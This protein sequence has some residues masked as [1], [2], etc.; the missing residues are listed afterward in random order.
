MAIREKIIQIRLLFVIFDPKINIDDIETSPKII[1]MQTQEHNCLKFKGLSN[2]WKNNKLMRRIGILIIIFNNLLSAGQSSSPTGME[3]A[4]YIP[5]EYRNHIYLNGIINNIRGNFIFDTG[6]DYLY[7]DSAFYRKGNFSFDSVAYGILPGA[8]NTPQKTKVILNPV[9]VSFHDNRYDSRITPIISLKTILGDYADGIIGSEYFM[10]G[11][12]EI[13]YSEKYIRI[14]NE[15]NSEIRDNYKAV[16]FLKT[17]G[18]IFVPLT[19]EINSSFSLTGKFILDLGSAGSITLTSPAAIK[20]SLNSKITKKI[21]LYRKY[22]GIGGDSEECVFT[23]NSATIGGYTLRHFEASYSLDKYG[24]LASDKYT[25]LIG[26]D[27]LDRFDLVIDFRNNC[28]YIKPNRSFNDPFHF[29]RTGFSYV[30]RSKTYG[31]WVVTGLVE[32][33]PAES[34]GLMIDDKITEINGIQVNEL[35]FRKQK[36]L[37]ENAEFFKIK[38]LRGNNYLIVEFKPVNLL[39]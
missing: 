2:K 37:V 3:Q 38:V 28:L 11:A 26:N 27:I 4:E 21:R 10:K 6:A 36:E 31:A 19:L 14:R 16:P 35:D 17:D 33:S 12:L 9:S 23:A 20:H 8:G 5:V 1:G 15:I 30:D 22:G 13:S 39:D 29:S 18:R 34:N 32:K 25:G 24:A 7:L